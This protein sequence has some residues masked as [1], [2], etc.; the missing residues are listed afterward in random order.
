[1]PQVN[2]IGLVGEIKSYAGASAPE[3]A[4][5]CQAGTIGD[6]GS[7]ADN[8]SGS[9]EELFDIIK[10]GWGNTGAEVFGDGDTVLLPDLRGMF[11]RGSGTHGSLTKLDGGNFEGPAVGNNEQDQANRFHQAA[12]GNTDS[13]T[14]LITIPENG[15]WSPIMSNDKGSA[16]DNI[17]FKLNGVETRPVNYGVNFIIIF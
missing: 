6:V 7:G 16:E 10:T 3:G 5:L 15:D 4:L 17:K 14:E 12:V 8:E 13:S 11:L 1:M 9:Y 2:N